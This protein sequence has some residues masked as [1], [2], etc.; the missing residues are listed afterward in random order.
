LKYWQIIKQLGGRV[1]HGRPYKPTT[2]GMIERS[3][4]Q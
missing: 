4:E 3:I 1:V 2:Q